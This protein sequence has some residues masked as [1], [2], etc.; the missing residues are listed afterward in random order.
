MLVDLLRPNCVAKK[1]H[2][3]CLMTAM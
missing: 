1:G 2:F 3:G